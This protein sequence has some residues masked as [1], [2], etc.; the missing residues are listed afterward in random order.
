M[1]DTGALLHSVYSWIIDYRI[2]QSNLNYTG[3]V[4]YIHVHVGILP[5]VTVRKFPE[6]ITI[7]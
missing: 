5:V 4:T 3:N 6:G 2:S 7:P 1:P